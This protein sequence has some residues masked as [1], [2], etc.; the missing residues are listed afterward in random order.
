VTAI[1]RRD[2]TRIA[3]LAAAA[4]AIPAPALA[5][6]RQE[7]AGAVFDWSP[8]AG[9]AAVLC[10]GQGGNAIVVPSA[11]ESL[12]IDC[13]NAGFGYALRAGA[14]REGAPL[15]FV[16]NTHHH[17]DHTGG[18]DAFTGALQVYAHRNAQPRVLAQ[19]ERYVQAIGSLAER[20]VGADDAR[21]KTLL[22]TAPP[23]YFTAGYGVLEDGD[24][25]PTTLI[26]DERELRFG[27]T[28]AHLRHVGAGHTDNDVFIHFPAENILHTGD[29]CFHGLHP[30]IDR[31]AGATTAGWIR[32]CQAMLEICDDDTVVVPGH[33]AVGGPEI[34][35][36]QID[37]FEKTRDAVQAAIDDGLD[38]DAVTNLSPAH[39]DGLGF[40][41]LKQRVLGAVYDEL[42]GAPAS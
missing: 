13:K 20:V 14:E 25:Q 31:P 39:F 27:D 12:L 3:A 28:A 36:K 40:E 24:W 8:I 35:Q 23:K 2:F 26:D 7:E 30:F 10:E 9:G 37:Y 5:F 16:V 38:R 32:S 19:R 17:A 6:L 34:M 15:R 29:L 33:G 41:Q 11:G 18:N 42:T 4:A 1:T 22:E 21:A